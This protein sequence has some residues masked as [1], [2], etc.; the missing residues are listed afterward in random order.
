MPKVTAKLLPAFTDS[1]IRRLLAV[2]EYQR[3]KAMILCLLDTG[4]RARKFLA[5]N[6]GDAN[7]MTGT[8]RV[9][10]MKNRSVW[11]VYLSPNLSFL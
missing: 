9:R 4:C 6:I 3:D 11:T 2:T 5:W 10:L 1:R 7:L 8:S